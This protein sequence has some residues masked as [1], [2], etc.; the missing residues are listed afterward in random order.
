MIPGLSARALNLQ[1]RHHQVGEIFAQV[2]RLR[3]T[4]GIGVQRIGIHRDEAPVRISQSIV[5]GQ[6]DE[7]LCA[8]TVVD[9]RQDLVF[10]QPP[11]WEVDQVRCVIIG[12]RRGAANQPL[13]RPIVSRT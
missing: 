13:L 3:V 10:C 9:I 7:T 5:R 8:E 6:E 12:E 2:A 1:L 4:E 11:F